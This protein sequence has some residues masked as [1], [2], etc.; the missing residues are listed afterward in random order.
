MA[1]RRPCQE[2]TYAADGRCC[3]LQN[4]PLIGRQRGQGHAKAE[5]GVA[6]RILR[7]HAVRSLRAPALPGAPTGRRPTPFTDALDLLRAAAAPWALRVSD[8]VWPSSFCVTPQEDGKGPDR[9]RDG[10]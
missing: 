4:H 3:C 9:V 5:G 10:G 1:D 8:A 2:G 6:L 7:E